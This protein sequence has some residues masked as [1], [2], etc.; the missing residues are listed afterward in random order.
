MIPSFRDDLTAGIA[1]MDGLANHPEKVIAVAAKARAAE[2]RAALT[3]HDWR[4][5]R[6]EL[7]YNSYLG[8][9]N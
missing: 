9:T 7:A 2:L 4:V 3:E 1:T 6:L 8:F 5:S